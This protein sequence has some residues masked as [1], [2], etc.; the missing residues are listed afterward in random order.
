MFYKPK[1]SLVY[2]AIVVIVF[3]YVYKTYGDNLGQLIVTFAVIDC[4]IAI[5]AI[6]KGFARGKMGMVAGGAICGII[7]FS[8]VK[9]ISYTSL[10]FQILGGIVG[11]GAFIINTLEDVL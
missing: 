6:V 5:L 9:D 1:I 10:F 3:Y 8:A 11:V 4:V 2:I 7:A